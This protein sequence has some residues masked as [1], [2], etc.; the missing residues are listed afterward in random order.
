MKAAKLSDY[1]RGWF[2]G[3]F[4]PSLEKTED[5]EVAVKHFRAG[6]HESLHYHKIAT[7]YTC[8]IKGSV[9]MFG[10][11]WGPGDIVI[12]EPGDATSFL[13][14]FDADLVVVKLPGAKNDKYLGCPEGCC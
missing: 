14:L 11:T 10:K 1:H 8:V 6:E 7:E 2:I 9:Q 13:A 3:D 4:D 12:A 5:V